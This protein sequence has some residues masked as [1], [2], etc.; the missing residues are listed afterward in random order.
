MGWGLVGVQCVY[1]GIGVGSS[2]IYTSNGIQQSADLKVYKWTNKR[3][4][5]CTFILW[6]HG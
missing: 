1:L 2:D 3:P 5:G 6:W 4:H